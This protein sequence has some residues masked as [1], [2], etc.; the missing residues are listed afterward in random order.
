MNDED[1]KKRRIGYAERRCIGLKVEGIVKAIISKTIEPLLVSTG[2]S[3]D[4]ETTSYAFE[5]K[6]CRFY[7]NDSQRINGEMVHIT[8]KGR[9]VIQRGQ[10][11][12]F[13]ENCTNK[14]KQ[15]I[16]WFAVYFD[17]PSS[18]NLLQCYM[19]LESFEKFLEDKKEKRNIPFD[20]VFKE[21]LDISELQLE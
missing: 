13:K 5:I 10:L 11:K 9:F 15:G 3:I 14:G 19:T 12:E 1:L 8:S 4:A 21:A 16:V 7:N 17:E 6:S 20:K 2:D 18:Y